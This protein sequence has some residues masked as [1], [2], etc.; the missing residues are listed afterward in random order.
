VLLSVISVAFRRFVFLFG[1]AEL[2]E[3]A[4]AAPPASG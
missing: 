2:G 4:R 1:P 3:R